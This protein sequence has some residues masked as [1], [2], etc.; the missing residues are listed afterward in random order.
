MLVDKVASLKNAVSNSNLF[1]K[2]YN[3]KFNNFKQK[4]PVYLERKKFIIKTAEN[5]FELKNALNLRHEVFYK[6]LLNKSSDIGLDIDHFDFECDHLIIIDKEFNKVVGTYRF[7]CSAFSDNFYSES[8]FYIDDIKEAKGTKL[9]LG[10]ACVHKSYRNG[11][12]MTLLLMGLFDY[13]NKVNAKYVFGCSSFNS[14]NVMEISLLYKYLND[15]SML[16]DE[17]VIFPKEEFRIPELVPTLD[18]LNK[19][20]IDTTHISDFIPPLLKGYIKG[21]AK[22]CGEPALDPKFK[23]ADFLTVI[24]TG[25]INNSHVKKYKVNTQ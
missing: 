8:E 7:I 14:T 9:E 19:F 11:I 17:F 6:E 10:R 15:T 18:V 23:C 21:G 25:N 24:D 2:V 1:Q 5:S 20:K 22:L 12:T 4:L 13:I 16:S 3:L